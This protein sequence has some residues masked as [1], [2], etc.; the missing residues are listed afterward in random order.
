MKEQGFIRK[1]DELG[2][3]VIPKEIRNQLKIKDNENIHIELI[4]ENV[5]IKKYSYLINYNNYLES[6]ANTFY[7]VYKI[8]IKI[9]DNDN[10]VVSVGSIND[11]LNITAPI[12]NNSVQIGTLSLYAENNERQSAQNLCKLLSK[13]ISIY[14]NNSW[15]YKKTMINY[16]Y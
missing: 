13:I 15:F 16:T 6:L 14:L 12:Y 1:I 8:P 2:R 9:K 4:K 3:V 7:E 5:I 10:L 11:K